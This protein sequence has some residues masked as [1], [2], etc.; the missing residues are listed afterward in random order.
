MSQSAKENLIK[1]AVA[2]PLLGSSSEERCRKAFLATFGYNAPALID[3][4]AIDA[5]WHGWK[6]CWRYLESRVTDFIQE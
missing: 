1:G 6:E 2:K 3:G 4:T 5:L